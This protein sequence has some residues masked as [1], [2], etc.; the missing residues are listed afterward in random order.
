MNQPTPSLET[1]RLEAQQV[2]AVP[3]EPIRYVYFPRDAVV[4]LLVPME[5][6]SA[7]EGATIGNE[8]IVGL[9]VFLGVR[10]MEEILVQVSG[11]AARM[12]ADD[13][14]AVLVRSCELQKLLQRYTLTLM[15]QLARTAE[16]NQVHSVEQRVARWLLMCRDR[17]CRETFPLTHEC[18]ASLLGV[19]RASISVAAEALRDAGMIVYQRGSISILDVERLKAAACQDYE[20]TQAG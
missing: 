4:S 16:C 17:A 2:L 7:V 10:A 18:L 20:P 9:E 12:R 8:G 13:F 6:G 3:D 11:E 19:R 5:D 1:V 15:T 14:R